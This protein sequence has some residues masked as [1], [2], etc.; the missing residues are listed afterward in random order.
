MEEDKK[1]VGLK[2]IKIKWVSDNSF[3]LDDDNVGQIDVEAFHFN[4]DSIIGKVEYP[5]SIV[6]GRYIENKGVILFILDEETGRLPLYVLAT[7][8]KNGNPNTFYGTLSPFDTNDPD[9]GQ[10]QAFIT[11]NSENLE[12]FKHESVDNVLEKIN[13]GIDLILDADSPNT[14][15][16][17]GVNATDY[18]AHIQ[19]IDDFKLSLEKGPFLEEFKYLDSIEF[20]EF[21]D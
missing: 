19:F 13:Y 14:I 7:V 21:E 1:I 17:H 18:D 4:D 3:T 16:F 6:V 8:I 15:M 11:V 12:E 9:N 10:D 5:F 2:H 20:E